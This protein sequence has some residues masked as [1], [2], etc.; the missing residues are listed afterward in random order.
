MNLSVIIVIIRTPVLFLMPSENPIYASNVATD[1]L[2][3]VDL[4]LSDTFHFLTKEISIQAA[5]PK[6]DVIY[7]MCK[8]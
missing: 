7:K 4:A 1:R 3:Y 6:I 5:K 2:A 8:T